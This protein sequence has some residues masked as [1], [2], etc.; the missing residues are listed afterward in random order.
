MQTLNI[1]ILGGSGFVGHHLCARLTSLGHNITVF[2][3]RPQSC[4][5]L[6][7]LPTV[8]VKEVDVFDKDALIEHTKGADVI[9]NLIGILNEKGHNGEGFYRAHVEV[10]KNVIEACKQNHIPRL[11]HMSALNADAKNAPSFYLLSKGEAEDYVH[12]HNSKNLKVTS[13]R[14]SVIYGPGDSFFN[15]FAKLLRLS[16]GIM[17]LPSADAQ[18]APIY[19][20]DVVNVMTQSLNMR[21][22]YGQRY[23]L[24]GPM[25][26]TLKDLVKYLEKITGTKRWVLGM[27]ESFS[28]FFAHIME[29]MPFKPYSVDNFHSATIPSICSEPFPAVFNIK[30]VQLENIVPTYLGTNQYNDDF[31]ELRERYS[32]SRL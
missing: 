31:A 28:S 3:R 24:C 21:E 12:A 15:L 6:K 13:F 7:I 29:Y 4:R 20:R 19:V 30:P 26:Y 16:P 14:P 32:K 11:L 22:T 9:I 23:D 25:V 2:S 10:T 27:N 1:V 18:F 5:D 8:Q 17:L